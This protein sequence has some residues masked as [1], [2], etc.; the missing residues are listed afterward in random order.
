MEK[1]V[2]YEGAADVSDFFAQRLQNEF[3]KD[4]SHKTYMVLDSYW[5]NLNESQLRSFASQ[6]T[7]KGQTPG[8]YFTPFSFWG[9][10]S[11]LDWSVPGTNEQYK[12]KDI[13]LR[14]NNNPIKVGGAFSLD[15]THPGTKQMLASKFAQFKSWGYRFIKLDF[16]NSGSVEADHYYNSAVTTGMQAYTEGMQYVESQLNDFFI[17]LSISPLF[18]N[19]GHAR[20]ISCD[21]WARFQTV[22]MF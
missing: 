19:F 5:D 1:K 6:C 17:D 18:P 9:K 12:Y 10:E 22:N 7:A 13:V 15:P 2:N 4:N 8:I 20:R 3:S 11:E 16:L 21:A 14:V